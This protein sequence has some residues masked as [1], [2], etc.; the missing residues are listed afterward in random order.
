ME[1]EAELVGGTKGGGGTGERT[2]K[3]RL[4]VDGGRSGGDEPP[5]PPAPLKSNKGALG[6]KVVHLQGASMDK[7]LTTLGGPQRSHTH[8]RAPSG[9]V[10]NFRPLPR[11]SH[12]LCGMH[13]KCD[14]LHHVV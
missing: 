8:F 2:E 3:G 14:S 5:S 1:W 13:H 4:G 7:R 10:G 12:S 9:V 6:I 11:N